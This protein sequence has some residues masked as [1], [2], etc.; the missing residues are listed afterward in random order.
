MATLVVSPL[1]GGF[2]E[3]PFWVLYLVQSALFLFLLV[4][5]LAASA[6]RL[7]TLDNDEIKMYEKRI[8]LA[9][10]MG[11]GLVLVVGAFAYLVLSLIGDPSEQA[12]AVVFVSY[13][14]LLLA[15]FCWH[16]WVLRTHRSFRAYYS[17]PVIRERTPARTPAAD[18]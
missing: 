1:F 10:C 11:A 17:L 12:V 18:N 16:V 14:C 5:I 3:I 8:S 15:W 2:F 6:E 4:L 7:N 13:S 9:I